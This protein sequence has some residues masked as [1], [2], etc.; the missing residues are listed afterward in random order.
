MIL[1]EGKKEREGVLIP[2]RFQLGLIPIPAPCL[3]QD[4]RDIQDKAG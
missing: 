2:V 3:N 1:G 4:D